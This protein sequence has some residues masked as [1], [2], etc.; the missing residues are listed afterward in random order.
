MRSSAAWRARRSSPRGPRRSTA[1]GLIDKVIVPALVAP[2][3]A[4]CAA[5]IAI[6]IAYRIIGRLRPGPVARGYRYG[7]LVSGSMFALAHGTND[8]QK[9]MGII[10]LALIAHGNLPAT[11]FEV[12]TWVI[13]TS[14]TAI[15]LGTYMGGWRIIRTRRQPHHQ[16]GLRAGL[17]G[18][19][20]RRRGRPHR[21]APRLPA[22]DDPRH[23]GRRHG[24]GRRRAGGSASLLC[25]NS[26]SASASRRGSGRSGRW[27]DTEILSQIAPRYLL[28][29]LSPILC[30]ERLSCHAPARPLRRSRK[31]FDLCRA[32][33]RVPVPGL[34]PDLDLRSDPP[35][36]P[37]KG[38]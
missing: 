16:D 6:L 15:A 36:K 4:F 31:P 24:L 18:P 25:C 1:Q 28:P 22:L 14:A 27:V 10:T 3:L 34:C 20:R 5:G 9:T 2:V 11:G 7:Q 21:D 19:G 12:P 35:G 26:M 37:A 23:L 30:K 33:V 38:A 13:V 32:R 8:A 29:A 17:L